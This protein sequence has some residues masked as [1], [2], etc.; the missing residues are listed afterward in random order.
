[1]HLTSRK[2]GAPALVSLL[3]MVALSYA[4]AQSV[5]PAHPYRVLVVAQQW[6]DPSG[7]VVTNGQDRFQPI[8]ALLK[9]WS[10][11]F[12][13][14]RLD[15]QRLDASY[16]FDRSGRVRYGAVLW[17]ADPTSYSEQDLDALAQAAKHGTG[18]IAINTRGTNP[19][20]NQ[21]LGLTFK[22]HYTSTDPFRLIENH[23]IDRAAATDGLPSQNRDYSDRIWMEPTNAQ[24]LVTQGEHPVLTLNE[25]DSGYSG[26][27]IGATDLTQLCTS[28]F[29]RNLVLRSLVWELGYAVLPDED[30]THRVIL[31]LDDWGTADKGFLNYWRYLEPQEQAIQQYLI[32]PLKKHNGV[33]S[34]MVD[35][36]YV[37]RQTKRIVSPW[38]QQFTDLYGLHQDYA[39]TLKGLKAGIAAGAIDIE[40][41]GWTHMEPDLESPPGPWW[42]ADLSGEGSVDGWYSEFQDRRRN[43]DVPAV[44]QLYH[45]NRSVDE[46]EHDFGVQPLELKPGGDA[47]SRSRFNNTA[48]LSARV[49]FGLFH[50]D[51]STY[52]LDPNIVLDM[53]GIVPDADTGFD[54]LPELHPEQWGYH[55]DGPVILGF[56]DRDIS[57]DQE[58]IDQLFAALPPGYRTI[59]ANEYI[60]VLHTRIE[61]STGNNGIEI[62]FGTDAHYCVYF[63]DHP[64]SWKL[65]LSDP[66]RKQMSGQRL[67]LSIDRQ[68][69]TINSVDVSEET[70]TIRIPAG[71]GSHSWKLELLG[72]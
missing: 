12:D 16:M 11:P 9:S 33:A 40:S 35:T 67:Q 44:A 18:F 22:Q 36:G 23:F 54:L 66:V 42:T 24:V 61:P 48:A 60:G 55:P 72:K 69:T 31:E 7:I 21:L 52:Y 68:R 28:P 25:A 59:A 64:S 38:T 71:T 8:A 49:G 29:W 10:I 34:A 6:S 14:L 19:V 27:W 63:A 15:E 32:D 70:T 65:W 50:G 56:H 45:I 62:T 46:I 47:W 37:D 2:L 43:E 20:L 4:G 30:Y 41:H 3:L 26:I 51:T 5:F 58:F 1:M 13:I 17:L 53:A 57:L 39:S